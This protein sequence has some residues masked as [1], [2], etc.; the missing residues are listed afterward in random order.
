[1]RSLTPHRQPPSLLPRYPGQEEAH[2]VPRPVFAL[3]GFAD[4]ET[5]AH[6]EDLAHGW[7]QSKSDL[8]NEA[9]C[10]SH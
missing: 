4:V 8:E 5:E 2:Q 1:M 9:P 10:P 6:R 7:S 3:L